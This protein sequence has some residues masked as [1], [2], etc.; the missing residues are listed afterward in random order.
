MI[1]YANTAPIGVNVSEPTDPIEE[2]IA[3]LNR[4]GKTFEV[5]D[6][7]EVSLINETALKAE[8]EVIII[9]SNEIILPRRRNKTA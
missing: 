7:C 2:V 3:Y 9:T 5:K 8:D 4:K 6:L 1:A